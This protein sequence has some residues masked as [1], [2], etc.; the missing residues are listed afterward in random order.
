MEKIIKR[1]KNLKSINKICQKNNI[2]Y[3]NF[4][5]GQISDEKRKLVLKDVK[6]EI[7]KLIEGV[8]DG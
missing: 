2:D 3:S 5:K 7:V 6:K 1:Y 4:M 8:I